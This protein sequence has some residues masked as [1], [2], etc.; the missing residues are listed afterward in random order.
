NL[1]FVSILRTLLH[2]T[3]FPI[4][5]QKTSLQTNF[6]LIM[7]FLFVMMAIRDEICPQSRK[8]R[9]AVPDSSKNIIL[10]KNSISR[11]TQ[12]IEQTSR[13]TAHNSSALSRHIPPSCDSI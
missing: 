7:R 4:L 3:A 8:G 11:P 12:S 5:L 6:R 10:R 1:W 13:T 9:Q 2:A